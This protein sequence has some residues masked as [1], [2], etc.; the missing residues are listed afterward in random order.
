MAQDDLQAVINGCLDENNPAAK[1]EFVKLF[2][3]LIAS[4]VIKSA[5]RFGTASTELVDD[6][7]QETYLRLFA[8]HARIL[9]DL[10]ADSGG[11]VFGLVQAVAFSTVQDYFRRQL[12]VKRGG[13]ARVHNIDSIDQ[14]AQAAPSVAYEREILLQ[15]IDALVREVAAPATMQRD[16][17][18][19]WLYYRHG[20]TTKAIA[21]LPFIELGAKGVESVI[22]RLTADVRTRIVALPPAAS[23]AGRS[24]P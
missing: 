14:T 3:R 17:C 12:A 22:H 6:L 1:A 9:R 7:I 20:F 21:E 5:R 19:F 8:E 16:R 15:K 13:G 24:L 2:H 11:G 18:I 23:S 4:T 10:R